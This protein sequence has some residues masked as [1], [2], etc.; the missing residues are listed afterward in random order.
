MEQVDNRSG[1]V[2]KKID[3]EKEQEGKNK[4]ELGA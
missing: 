2:A 1:N 3:K 4:M